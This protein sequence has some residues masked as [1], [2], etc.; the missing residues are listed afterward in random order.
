MNETKKCKY[1]QTDIPKKAKV[2]PNCKKNLKSHGCLAGVS[3]FLCV[4]V[5]CIFIAALSG[6]K[7]E[8]SADLSEAT[9]E[10]ITLDEFNT[11][12]NGMS[13]EEVVEIIGSEG[14]ASS[15]ATVGD[16][17]TSIYMWKGKGSVGANAN[18]TFIDN[19]VSAK[20]QF[21]LE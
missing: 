3:I 17:T 1:C 9:A 11:I 15:T 19:E 12:Q 13:Y 8:I 6:S 2:C 21:G 14:E 4:I 5:V 10:L 7:D 18:V 20:A 16:I